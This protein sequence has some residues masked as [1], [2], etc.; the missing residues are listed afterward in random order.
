MSNQNI[1]CNLYICSM[2][3]EQEIDFKKILENGN[4]LAEK[5]PEILESISIPKFSISDIGLN[6]R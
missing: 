4:E 1:I 3:K 2:T 6:A 5:F